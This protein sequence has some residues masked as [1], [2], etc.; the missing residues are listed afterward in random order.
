MN[1]YYSFQHRLDD[2]HD[3]VHFQQKLQY[4]HEGENFKLPF[5]MKYKQPFKLYSLAQATQNELPPS[6]LL[7][8]A[9]H[10]VAIY[11]DGKISIGVGWCPLPCDHIKTSYFKHVGF[12]DKLA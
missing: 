3:N 2:K 5:P 9:I 7:G 1:L 12:F 10:L 6:I 8:F 11:M 4:I